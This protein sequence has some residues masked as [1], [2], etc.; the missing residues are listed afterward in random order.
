VFWGVGGALAKIVPLPGL[1]LGF[2]RLWL[3]AVV[4]TGLLLVTG[5]RLSPHHLRLALPGGL[6]F[7]LNIAFFFVAVKVTT[8]ANATVISAL[9]PALVLVVVNRLFGERVSATDVAWTL[10]AIAGVGVVV[11][12]SAGVPEASL[13]GDALA[14]L[15]LLA[16]TW[17][18]V[19]SKRARA[20]LDTLEYQAAISVVGAVVLGPLALLS[21]QGLA[22]D[23]G[24]VWL[25]VLALVAVPGAGHLL[26]NWAHAYAPLVLTSLLT[27]GMPVIST[28][29]A[30]LAL[31]EPVAALQ[32]AGMAVVIGALAVVVHRSGRAAQPAVAPGVGS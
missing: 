16:W 10:V 4:M 18:F 12:G 23:D 2:H 20:R 11:F 6:A 29:V 22:V 17:Y 25:G 28:V 9:Q 14:V 27:L 7:G 1:V 31:A 26:M 19:A 15:A 30:A 21:G 13:R 8:V 32:V 3:G 5:G 24:S